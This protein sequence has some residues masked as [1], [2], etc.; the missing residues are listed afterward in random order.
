MGTANWPFSM[1]PGLSMGAMNTLQLHGDEDQRQTYLTPMTEGRWTGTMCLTEP[2]CGTDLGQVRTKAVRQDDGSYRLTGTKIFISS[3][4]HD[5]A[6]NI[7]HIVLAR[8]P[9]APKGTKGISLFIV[10]KY[11]PDDQGNAG[12]ANGVS[13]GA[14]EEDGDQGVG[15]L[16]HE[17]R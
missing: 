6:E 8:T 3:G 14:L 13:V 5:L 4:D 2:Q 15:H 12:E 11:L 10:P 16:H 1:Y 7:V 9:G 17:L